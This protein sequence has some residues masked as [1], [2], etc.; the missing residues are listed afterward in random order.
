MLKSIDDNKRSKFM[1]DVASSKD[2]RGSVTADVAQAYTS[3]GG[4]GGASAVAQTPG[5][6]AAKVCQ[7]QKRLEQRELEVRTERCPHLA[8]VT[9]LVNS[10]S[11]LLIHSPPRSMFAL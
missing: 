9:V 2:R 8:H 10:S 7:L 4:D 11:A 1:F 6:L 3:G 5:E